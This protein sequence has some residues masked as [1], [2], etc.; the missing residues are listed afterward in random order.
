MDKTKIERVYSGRPGCRCGCRGKYYKRTDRAFTRI[1]NLIQN[2]SPIVHYGATRTIWNTEIGGRVY[3]AYEA[4][5]ETLP[6]AVEPSPATS[7][8]AG[9]I[10][11]EGEALARVGN[12]REFFKVNSA[13]FR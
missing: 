11:D 1:I 3:S 8:T 13:M 10:S 5:P 7:T 9:S 2:N 6:P 4:E 12:L